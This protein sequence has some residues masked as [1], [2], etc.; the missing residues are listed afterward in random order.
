MLAKKAGV[1]VTDVSDVAIWG[2]HSSTQVPDTFHAKIHGKDLRELI[3]D[4]SWLD[5]EFFSRVQKRG[6]EVIAARGKSSAASAAS[7]AIDAMRSLIYPTAAGHFF[8][9]A[10]SSMGNPYG[11][12]EDLIF[13]F[14]CISRGAGY[15]EIVKGLALTPFLQEKIAL[16]EKELQEER[17]LI[18]HLRK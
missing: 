3:K 14:P 18:T 2:N 7:S 4:H 10:L 5:G 13:S 15:I 12:D 6:A 1:A 16:S 11:I 17:S 9:M 8:S